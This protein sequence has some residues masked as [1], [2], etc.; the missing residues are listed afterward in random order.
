VGKRLR[1]VGPLTVLAVLG[2][3][4]GVLGPVAADSYTD[5]DGGFLRAGV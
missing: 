3:V 1:R 2:L 4:V 5:D